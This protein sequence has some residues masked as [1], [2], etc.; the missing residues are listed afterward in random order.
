MK[1]TL[2]PNAVYQ[3]ILQNLDQE[4]RL[5]ITSVAEAVAIGRT[6]PVFF[7]EY[8]LRQIGISCVKFTTP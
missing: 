7:G 8:F 4:D 1:D 2:N 3:K 6:D 5:A